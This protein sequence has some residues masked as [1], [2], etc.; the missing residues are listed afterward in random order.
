MEPLTV[1][2]DEI[3]DAYLLLQDSV[4]ALALDTRPAQSTASQGYK[5]FSFVALGYLLVNLL[6][7]RT[8][9]PAHWLG[10]AD[11]VQLFHRISSLF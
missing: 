6:S 1:R 2:D 7:R 10:F 3:E 5:V 8:P 11:H 4:E 9:G